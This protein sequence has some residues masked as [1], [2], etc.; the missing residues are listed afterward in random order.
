MKKI[1]GTGVALAL[2][3]GTAAAADMPVYKAPVKAPLWDVA[4]GGWIASDY[5]FRG[6]SQSDR[7]ASTGA[8]FELQY[9]G[10]LGGQAY[11]GIA[12]NAIELNT[13]TEIDI[14]AGW[15]KTWGKFGLDIG[16]FYYWYPK[17]AGFNTDF[18]EI[19][20]KASYAVTDAFT[21]GASV[22]YTPDLLNLGTAAGLSGLD[23]V[24]YEASAK[25]VLP[26]STAT[27]YGPLGMFVSGAIGHWDIE[28]NAAFIGGADA[29]YT[30]WNAGVAFTL[31]AL[32][33]DLRYH[34][35]DLS[36]AE[37]VAFTAFAQAGKWC[38]STFIAKLSFDTLLSKIKN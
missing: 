33:L 37:C 5:N 28:Q 21:I 10:I 25:Y 24:Y 12:G 30:Y 15:R 32:T 27:A 1:L 2:M 6:I 18:F 20:A 13:G 36:P 16:Y 23:G 3:A 14:Y 19:Y 7:H 17:E 34:D 26:F 29:S 8:Y 9:N 4:I 11:A 35:T 31:S 22:F 38:S